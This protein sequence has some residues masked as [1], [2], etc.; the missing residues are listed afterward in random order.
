MREKKMPKRHG[1]SWQTILAIVGA[2]AAYVAVGLFLNP[3][4]GNSGAYSRYFGPVLPLT[5]VSGGE[6]L[7][8]QRHVEFDFS[9]YENYTPTALR[10]GEAIVTDTYRLTNPGDSD[11][12][13]R[14]VYPYEGRFNDE[15]KYTPTL[16]VDGEAVEAEL[17][18]S[19]DEQQEIFR[20]QDFTQYRE[21]MEA[22]DFFAQA[23]SQPPVL[24]IPVKVYHFTDITYLGQQEYPYIFLTMEFSIPEGANVWVNH[25]DVLSSDSEKGKHS[26]WFQDNLDDRDGA[27]LFVMNGD[28]EELTFGGNLGHNVTQTS[29]LT[30]VAYEYET[31]ETTFAELVWELAR[32][33]DYWADREDYPNPGLIT[34]ESLYR[35]AMK[36]MAD[37]VGQG[38]NGISGAAVSVVE[39]W[40]Y[41]TVTQTR[42]LYWVF[43]VT[44]PAGET[45]ELEATFHQEASSDTSGSKKMREGYDL[46]T[47]LGSSLDFTALSASIANAEYIDIIRQNFGFQPEKGITRVD[48]DLN[49]ERYYLEVMVKEK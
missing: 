40:F 13:A 12:T 30:D 31:Y 16:T 47:R 43:D 36:R 18:A 17:F 35:D 34:P 37:E 26:I 28:I 14:L 38:Y 19:L 20:A 45:V 10:E 9:T 49:E 8:A 25:F 27:Y 15:R 5:A 4:G 33:Y 11:V 6:A 3:A 22:N 7:E 32:K 21:R 48:L 44:V 2:A 29:A 1:P 23:V 42:L 46:A 39:E 24:D 41:K